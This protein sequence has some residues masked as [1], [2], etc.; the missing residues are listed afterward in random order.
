MTTKA[1]I[2]EKVTYCSVDLLAPRNFNKLYS[3]FMA[4]GWLNTF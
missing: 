1:Q 4:K 3:N 2:E